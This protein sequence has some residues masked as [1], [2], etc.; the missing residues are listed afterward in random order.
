MDAALPT[1]PPRLVEADLSGPRLGRSAGPRDPYELVHFALNQ[2]CPARW[3]VTVYRTR[4]SVPVEVLE[5]FALDGEISFF[6]DHLWCD[7][8]PGQD[9]LWND[10]PTDFRS[11]LRK[12][13]E[14]RCVKTMRRQALDA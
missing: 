1:R 8:G 14:A 4:D 13:A 11:V 3:D 7:T 2:R 12:Y 10:Y 6:V 5:A 9:F